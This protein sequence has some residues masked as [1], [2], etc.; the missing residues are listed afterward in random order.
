MT[1]P[2]LDLAGRRFGR[3]TVIEW[4]GRTTTRHSLWRCACLCGQEI[5][6]RRGNLLA[7]FT[8]SC[9]CL[10]SERTAIGSTKHGHAKQ[11]Q[12]S[13][14]YQ[15]WHAM[16]ARCAAKPGRKNRRYRDYVARGIKVCQRWKSFKNFLAD[17]GPRPPGMTLDRKNNEG[18][19]T[20]RNCRWATHSE[21]VRNRRPSAYA[22][23]ATKE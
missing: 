13:P 1:K 16:R 12:K 20:P 4:V 11:D 5:V 15:S 2:K 7:G 19:Y 14:E 23:R 18:N 9:G 10:R 21:Q 22:R 17:M 3:L 8:R 6:A